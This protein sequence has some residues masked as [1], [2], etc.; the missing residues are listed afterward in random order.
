MC[1]RVTPRVWRA[2]TP[3]G[4]EVVLQAQ[5]RDLFLSVFHPGTDEAETMR[6]TEPDRLA[7]WRTL[8]PVSD[9]AA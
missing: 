7:L 6:L 8:A 4:R 2:T 1:E 5:D 9:A 3:D